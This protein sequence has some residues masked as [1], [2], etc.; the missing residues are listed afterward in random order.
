MISIKQ[1]E[2][3][4]LKSGEITQKDFAQKL[5]ETYPVK[6]IAEAFVELLAT[7]DNVLPVAK[8]PISKELLEEHFR[9]IGESNRGRKR[10]DSKE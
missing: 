1:K 9:I 10:K 8:I 6:A 3:K 4:Q 2:L 7:A 5:I